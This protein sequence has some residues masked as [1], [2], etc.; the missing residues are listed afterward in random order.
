MNKKKLRKLRK[1]LWEKDPTC[2]VCK[3]EIKLYLESS[4]E[5][6]IPLSLGGKSQT[7]NLAISHRWC[8]SVRGSTECPLIWELKL[9]SYPISFR[10][11]MIHKC[12]HLASGGGQPHLSGYALVPSGRA[13][14]ALDDN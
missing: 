14:M 7:R 4:I 1:E 3:C 9:S 5:H 11:Q 12:I 2:F 10:N 13:L 6:I 8:N